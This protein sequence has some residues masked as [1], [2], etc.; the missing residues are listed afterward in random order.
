MKSVKPLSDR[1][2]T[3]LENVARVSLAKKALEIFSLDLVGFQQKVRYLLCN[4]SPTI[5]FLVR[6]VLGWFELEAFLYHGKRFTKLPFVKQQSYFE[7]WAQSRFYWRYLFLRPVLVF[8]DTAF[9]SHSLVSS[10]LGFREPSQ[11]KTSSSLES[12]ISQ[13]IISGILPVPSKATEIEVD[14]CV[15]GSGAGGAVIAKELAEK[16]HTVLILEA[17]SHYTKDDFNKLSTLER[18]NLIYRDGG[19]YATF[20]FPLVLLPTG[21]CVGGTTVIN[22]GT[23][24]RTPA[25]ILERWR[26]EFGLR[27]LSLENLNAY[28]DRVESILQVLPV[29]DSVLGKNDRVLQKG[30]E[31]LGLHGGPLLRNA[32]GCKG[33]GVCI[34]GCPTGAKQ[35]MER[36]YLPLAFKAGA[37]LYSHCHAHRLVTQFDTNVYKIEAT[38]HHPTL[39][40]QGIPFTV[41]PKQ[42]VV[43]GGTLESPLLLKRSGIGLQS[44]ALGKNLT[45]HPTAKVVGVFEE[46]ING[47][48][49]VPQ[50]YSITDFEREGL[51]FESVFF[52]PWLLATSLHQ[53]GAKKW[54]ILEAYRH[55]AI[56]GFLVHDQAHGRVIE[57]SGGRPIVFYQMGFHEKELFAKGLK[58]LCRLFFA[59]G[60]KKIYPTLRNVKEFSSMQEVEKFP[61]HEIKRRDLEVAA[62]HPL[63]TCRMGLDP[64][65]SVVDENQKVHGIENLW[66]ADGSVF[67]TSLGVNPQITI[68]A[69]AT[70]CAHIIDQAV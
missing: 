52:P 27:N 36:S 11:Q 58:I 61:F 54:E 24:F 2:Y 37:K 55:L 5:C 45:L 48:R 4:S 3:I 51:L 20:G 28:F 32:L 43:S 10:H 69:F 15:I 26:S 50:A 25:S 7:K 17:G 16:G 38:F 49:G 6:L 53:T 66:I 60:A 67:P 42:V 62:F 70:R 23:C 41:Y 19:M 34:F 47:Y 21:K 33:S 22:S 18:N 30:M 46:Q 8:V 65:T 57:G 59:A 14:I 44:R 9:F 56:F 35:S 39:A 68:M 40:S 13:E 63:G 1:T 12:G 31:K 29:P 64:K